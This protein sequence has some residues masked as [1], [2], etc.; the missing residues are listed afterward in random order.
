MTLIKNAEILGGS[1]KFTRRSDGTIE[2]GDDI[3]ITNRDSVNDAIDGFEDYNTQL[4]RQ[5]AVNKANDRYSS[6]K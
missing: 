3:R 2:K 5:N 1:S 6:K 4:N